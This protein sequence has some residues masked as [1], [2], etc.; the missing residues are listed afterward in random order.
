L[1]VLFLGVLF[2]DPHFWVLVSGRFAFGSSFPGILVL[3]QSA[4]QRPTPACTDCGI[5]LGCEDMCLK[6]FRGEGLCGGG[7]R[8]V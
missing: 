3:V 8:Q 5:R 7:G 6:V 2:L 1:G 4:A